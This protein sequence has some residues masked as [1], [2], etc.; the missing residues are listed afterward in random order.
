MKQ[1]GLEPV[2][3]RSPICPLRGDSGKNHQNTSWVSRT[4]LRD[5]VIYFN[6][7]SREDL[8]EVYHHKLATLE[9][10]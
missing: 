7:L 8:F 4:M 1:K 6:P 9:L 2:A 10:G 5:A 3:D